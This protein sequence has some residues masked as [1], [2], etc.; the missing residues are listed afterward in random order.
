[1]SLFDALRHRLRPLFRRGDF[2][3]E[4]SEEFRHHLELEAQEFPDGDD[5]VARARAHFGSEAWY[6]EETRRMTLLG[7]VD[8]LGQDVRYAWRN[9]RRAPAFTAVAVLSLAIGIGA[10]SAIFGLLYSLLL[11]PLPV[12]HPEQLVEVQHIARASRRTT[13]SRTTSTSHC[14]GVRGSRASRRLAVPVACRSSSATIA[15]PWAS[16]RWTGISSQ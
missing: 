4:M 5:P 9:L 12:S 15:A 13:P 16:T 7:W 3:H 6:M 8:A 10:N 11:Q 14:G 2:D 1:M